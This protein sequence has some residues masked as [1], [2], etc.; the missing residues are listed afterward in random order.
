MQ[1]YVHSVETSI[2]AGP[3]TVNSAPLRNPV[4][5]NHGKLPNAGPYFFANGERLPFPAIS[6]DDLSNHR[7]RFRR[8]QYDGNT[9]NERQCGWRRARGKIPAGSKREMTRQ[10]EAEDSAPAENRRRNDACTF[11][12]LRY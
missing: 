3:S 4:E 10:V 2:S 7:N 8:Q 9:H 11:T 1:H 6:T 5:A 12:A